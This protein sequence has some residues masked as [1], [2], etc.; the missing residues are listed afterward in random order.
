MKHQT[1]F[2]YLDEWNKNEDKLNQ[3]L[4]FTA[5]YES[6]DYGIYQE[7]IAPKLKLQLLHGDTLYI[8]PG[9]EEIIHIETNI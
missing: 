4:Y 6:A 9:L 5:G 8:A 3:W 2:K 7:R 1:L